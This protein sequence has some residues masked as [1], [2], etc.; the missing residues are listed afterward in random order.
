MGYRLLSLSTLEFQYRLPS[1]L[2]RQLI[3]ENWRKVHHHGKA[4]VWG[5]CLKEPW[6]YSRYW[7][8]I[9]YQ[10]EHALQGCSGPIIVRGSPRPWKCHSF[11][12]IFP[13]SIDFATFPPTI[14]IQRRPP[15]SYWR[16]TV[17]SGM[18]SLVGNWYLPLNEVPL[19]PLQRPPKSPPWSN[20]FSCINFPSINRSMEIEFHVFH[21]SLKSVTVRIQY[22]MRQ[23]TYAESHGT[24]LK[25]R[26]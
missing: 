3:D 24:V 12:S 20:A 17:L 7:R 22:S 4:K 1:I 8:S 18:F 5:S 16:T 14:R 19:W 21:R 6:D 13:R 25:F 23:Y 15:K 9:S 26:S 2:Q 10:L 11:S